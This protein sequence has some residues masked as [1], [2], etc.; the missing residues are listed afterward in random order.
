M[1]VRD[2]SRIYSATAGQNHGVVPKGS[3][4]ARAMSAAMTNANSR[5]PQQG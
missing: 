4:A 2:A 1:T 5:N 3:F